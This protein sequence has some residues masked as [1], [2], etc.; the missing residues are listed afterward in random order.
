MVNER[1]LNMVWMQALWFAAVIGAAAGYNWPAGLVL[2]AFIVWQTRPVRHAKG[3]VQLVLVAV[4]MGFLFDTLW[5]KLDWLVFQAAATPRLAPFWIVM[6]WAGLALTI[7]HSLAWLQSNWGLGALMSGVACP[8][9]YL[10][11]EKL[12]AVQIIP[13]SNLWWLIMGATWAAVVPFLL[14][15]SSKLKSAL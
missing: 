7:N 13:D 2:L 15:L 9:S 4:V 14:W 10:G 8:L 12:G 3:D 11:A 6:L 5:V 1:I